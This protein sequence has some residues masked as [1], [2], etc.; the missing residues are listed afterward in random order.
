MGFSFAIFGL[1]TF[2]GTFIAENK[3]K[4]KVTNAGYFWSY[5]ILLFYKF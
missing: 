4:V 3:D 2:V 5:S 1:T